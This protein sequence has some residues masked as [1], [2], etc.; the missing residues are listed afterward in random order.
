[1]SPRTHYRSYW[2]QFLQ[3]KWSNQQSTAAEYG[4]QNKTSIQPGPP[5]YVTVLKH[6]IQYKNTQT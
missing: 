6:V 3:V 1:M 2:G 5:H 4:S